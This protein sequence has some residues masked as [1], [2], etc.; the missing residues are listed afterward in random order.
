MKYRFDSTFPELGY[1]KELL[2]EFNLPTIPV[3]TDDTKLYD[4]A[5][6]IKELG[7]YRYNSSNGKMV[8]S[9]EYYFNRP[10]LNITTNMPITT[11]FYSTDIHEYLGK[12]LRF[13]RDYKHLN[14]MSLYNCFSNRI[15]FPKDTK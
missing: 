8:K 12:Y 6:Y 11:S 5:L 1:I 15:I 13:I 14:L 7:V 4:K 10:I 2:K 3:A 9:S